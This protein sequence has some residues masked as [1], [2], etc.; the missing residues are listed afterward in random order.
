MFAPVKTLLLKY[1]HTW[2]GLNENVSKG[3]RVHGLVI[4]RG[5]DNR[6]LTAA[7]TNKRVEFVDLKDLG[8]AE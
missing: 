2:D 7:A 1:R 3:K 4:A 8:F 6:F 5:F